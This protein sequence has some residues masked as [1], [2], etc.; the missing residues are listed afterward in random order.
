MESYFVFF[1]ALIALS[2]VC[3]IE[4]SQLFLSVLVDGFHWKRPYQYVG[5]KTL[6]RWD[7]ATLVLVKDQYYSLYPTLS[8][9]I[10]EACTGSQDISKDI[11]GSRDFGGP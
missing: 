3:L 8:L 1:L 6:A 10:D 9:E 5:V 4:W 2:D 7:V 11:H